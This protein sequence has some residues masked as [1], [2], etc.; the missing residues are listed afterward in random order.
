MLPYDIHKYTN[1]YDAT[2]VVV[3]YCRQ[4]HM[5]LQQIW[6][7]MPNFA[8]L[9][10][11]TCQINNTLNICVEYMFVYFVLLDELVMLKSK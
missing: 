3:L 9:S 4:S 5:G 6:V 8:S 2:T 11:Y 1:G 10:N 7:K